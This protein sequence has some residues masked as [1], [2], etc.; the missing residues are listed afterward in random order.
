[1]HDIE[2][3]P[4]S[5]IINYWLSNLLLLLI[6]I[7]IIKKSGSITS[8][9]DINKGIRIFALILLVLLF[10][11]I[12]PLLIDTSGYLYNKKEYPKYEVCQVKQIKIHYRVLKTEIFFTCEDDRQYKI[13]KWV[14]NLDKEV[15]LNSKRGK[16]ILLSFSDFEQRFYRFTILPE[17]KKVIEISKGG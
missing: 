12:I 1:M 8:R 6:T 10:F 13:D 2:I 3:T 5:T 7:I 4:V 11:E 17:T 9:P 14:L 15:I 16:M